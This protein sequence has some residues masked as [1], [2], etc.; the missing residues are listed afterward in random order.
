MF[1]HT[2][3]EK[4]TLK[5]LLRLSYR[6]RRMIREGFETMNDAVYKDFRDDEL[7]ANFNPRSV[8]PD[9]DR[10]RQEMS[11][12]SDAARRSLTAYLNVAYGTGA[13]EAVDIFPAAAQ[14]APVQLYIH[15]GFWRAQSKEDHSYVARTFVSA[16]VTTVVMGYDLC[17]QVTLTDIVRQTRAA[18]SWTFRN[19][20]EYGGDP[21]RLYLS[22]TSAG[23]HLVAMAL[24]HDWQK[25]EGLPA[26]TLKGATAI[27]GVLNLEPVRHI[28]VNE[29]IRLTP[30]SAR[31]NNPLLHPPL[32]HV[33][34][35]VAVGLGETAGWIGMSLDFAKMCRERDIACTYLEIPDLH[36]YQMALE[37]NRAESALTRAILGQMGI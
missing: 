35:I 2:V 10:F 26:N 5:H 23:G 18:I 28:S 20:A 19:I 9:H 31:L 15:G 29:Q 6:V 14:D 4:V 21:S 33:P 3:V 30:D 37:L 13:R 16:G 17:P 25:E 34:L 1:Q 7:E 27:S 24:A 36:H 32:G 12:A 8:I 11:D 22:G